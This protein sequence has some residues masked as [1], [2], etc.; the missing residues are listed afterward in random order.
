[1]HE[2]VAMPELDDVL[3][4]GAGT[5]LVVDLDRAV[6]RERARIHDDDR[7][8]PARLIS[9]TSGWSSARPIRHD[10]VDGRATECAREAA[11]QRRDEVQRVARG[12]RGDRRRPR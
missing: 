2:H 9:S 5:A 8:T 10:A 1:M 6:T 12:F 11:V 7:D 3:G 4:R